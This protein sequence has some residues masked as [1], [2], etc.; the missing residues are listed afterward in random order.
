MSQMMAFIFHIEGMKPY[1]FKPVIASV[2]ALSMFT[3]C[4]S[5]PKGAVA[6]KPFDKEKYLGKWYEI[7]RLDYKYERH[8]DHVTAEYGLKPNGMISV[9]NKGYNVKKEKWEESRGKAKS[10]SDPQE[11]MLKV[12]FFGPFY[13]GYNV[14]AIDERYT[15]ALVAGESTSY[16]WLLSREKTMPEDIKKQFLKQAEAIG[17]DTQK[18]VWVK[19]D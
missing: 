19:Q 17:Y 3:S 2:L 1:F 9:I 12:S 8:L 7:A 4:K 14:I 16:L 10:A 13:A 15:Y 5:I 18:L 11:A 6:V